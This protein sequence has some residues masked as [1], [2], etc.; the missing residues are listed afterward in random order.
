MT[1][2]ASKDK[3]AKGCPNEACECNKKKRLYKADDRYCVKCGSELLWVCRRCFRRLHSDD[4]SQ[5]LCRVCQAE[6]EDLIQKVKKGGGAIVGGVG[7]V[8]T[9]GAIVAQKYGP[10]I[11]GG[12]AK[13]AGAASRI[14]K[15]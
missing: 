8:V 15:H 11:A 2:M 3:R 5:S 12:A 14:L 10:Q 13:V 4:P 1:R 6:H 7:T 9:G